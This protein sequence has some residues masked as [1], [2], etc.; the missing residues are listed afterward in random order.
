MVK[1]GIIQDV[2]R[3]IPIYPDPTYRPSPKPA[4]LSIPEVPRSLFDSDP[5]INTNFKKKFTISRGC[6]LRNVPKIR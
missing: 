2:S 4:K 3:L 6:D 5:E 1:R